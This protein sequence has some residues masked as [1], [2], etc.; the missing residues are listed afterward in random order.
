[1]A[2][3]V[4]KRKKDVVKPEPLKTPILDYQEVR[5]YILRKHKLD[6]HNWRDKNGAIKSLWD[7][8]IRNGDV[9]NGSLHSICRCTAEDGPEWVADIITLLFDEFDMYIEGKAP[10]DSLTF[11]VTW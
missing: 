11:L 2:K 10:Y 9:Q 6:L 1:M 7:W 4:V 5:D 8:L 3:K